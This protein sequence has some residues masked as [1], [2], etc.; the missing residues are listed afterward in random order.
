MRRLLERDL[1]APDPLRIGAYTDQDGRVLNQAGEPIHRLYTLGS[2][3]MGF[4]Y[5]SI[6]VPEL[7]V[8]ANDLAKRILASH[9][10]APNR[11]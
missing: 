4:L 2:P 7:R 6:A 9:R 8:Q 11:R 3:R 1:L 5:E 10:G